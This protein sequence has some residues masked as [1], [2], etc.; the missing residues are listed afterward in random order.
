M[1][2]VE[3]ALMRFLHSHAKRIGD[4]AWKIRICIRSNDDVKGQRT[5]EIKCIRNN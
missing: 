2:V 5:N 4:S 1:V 3:R